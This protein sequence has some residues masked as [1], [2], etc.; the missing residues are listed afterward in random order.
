M[1]T[2]VKC[3]PIVIC[4]GSGGKGKINSLLG[5]MIMIKGPRL[6]GLPIGCSG[7]TKRILISLGMF[8]SGFVRIPGYSFPR[9]MKKLE[10]KLN[11]S[12]IS[13][14]E[15]FTILYKKNS[16]SLNLNKFEYKQ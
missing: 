15:S 11:K 10:E 7:P 3:I 12:D 9:S 14:N 2:K 1:G 13:I 16:I 6:F 8:K 5:F 4:G